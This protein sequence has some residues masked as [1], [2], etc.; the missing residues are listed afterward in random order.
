MYRKAKG[1]QDDG[2]GE[3][4]EGVV[5]KKEKEWMLV[6]RDGSIV[7]ELT[8]ITLL[9]IGSAAKMLGAS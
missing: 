9:M 4:R 3:P 5:C 6:G 7:K 8:V 2:A 1:A